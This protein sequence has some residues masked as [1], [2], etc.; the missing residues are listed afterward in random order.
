MK[1]ISRERPNFAL[2]DFLAYCCVAAAVRHVRR[3]KHFAIGL[4]ISEWAEVD[5]YYRAAHAVLK[6]GNKKFDVGI[7]TLPVIFHDARPQTS[8]SSAIEALEYD[9]VILLFEKEESIPDDIR[10]ALDVVVRIGLPTPQQAKGVLRW[11][12]RT[13]ISDLQAEVLL[14]HDW[15]RLRHIVRP[16]RPIS[17]VLS[18][19]M[20]PTPVPAAPDRAPSRGLDQRLET[21]AGYGEARQWG[22]EL[23]TDIQDWKAGRIKWHDVDRGLLLS[24]PPGTGKTIYANA[25]ARTCGIPVVHASAAKWQ[26]KGHLGD[27]LSA[28]R[29]SFAEAKKLAPAILFVD[30][31]DSFGHRNDSTDAQASSYDTKAINGFLE[32]LDGSQDRDGVVVVAACNY[33]DRIDDAILRSGRV[34]RQI[35]IELPDTEARE[36]ILRVHL[37]GELAHKDITEFARASVGVTGADIARLVRD[38]RRLARRQGRPVLEE[39]LRAVMPKS[40]V[41]PPEN[42]NANAVHE[43]GHAVVGVVLGLELHHVTISPVA[44]ITSD[45]QALGGARFAAQQWLRRTKQHYLD[46]IAVYLAGRAAEDIFLGDHDDGWAGVEGS[47]LR[48]ATR[49]AIKMERTLAM[50]EHLIGHGDI[51]D[52]RMDEISHLDPALSLRVDGILREQLVRAENIIQAHRDVA[53]ALHGELLK[54]KVLPG[55][56]VLAA[57]GNTVDLVRIE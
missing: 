55:A 12:H 28:M 26:S 43:I 24:G 33:P 53:V 44:R 9:R 48:Q 1:F 45:V 21:M 16:G 4:V 14:A 20:S 38:A 2:P 8:H 13:E 19:L 31:L 11:L 32:C 47:D 27:F 29:A 5:T 49:L 18:T 15:K 36:A 23:A 10:V 41:V 37:R 54:R 35:R 30:E 56:D 34:D 6:P 52:R 25:L 39:D 57:L 7:R 17:R 50:G 3:A 40:V 46:M 51:G 22:L 42:L